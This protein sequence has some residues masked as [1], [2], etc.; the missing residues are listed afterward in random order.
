MVGYAHTWMDEWLDKW[1][2][3]LERQKMDK[4]D[5]MDRIEWTGPGSA[6]WKKNAYKD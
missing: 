3:G 2:L 5:R 1:K 6:R 4:R